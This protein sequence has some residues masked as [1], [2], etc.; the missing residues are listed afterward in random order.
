M[1]WYNELS[2][3][4]MS[5]GYLKDGQTIEERIKEMGD[6]AQS[7]LNKEGYSDK[8]QDYCKRGWFIEPTPCWTNF[9]VKNAG[10]AVSCF[11]LYIDDNTPSILTAVAEAGMQSKIGGGTSGY[12]GKIRPRGSAITGGGKSNGAVSFMPLFETNSNVI[13]QVNRRGHFSATLDIEHA[14]CDEFL[15][16]RSEGNPI[17]ELSFSISIS[18]KFMQKVYEE[19][20]VA[21]EKL[22]KVAQSRFHTGFPYIF[23]SDNVNNNTVD[24][25]KETLS[26]IFHSNMCQPKEATLLLKTNI[27]SRIITMNELKIG[28]IIWSG[29]QWTKVINK[30]SN[31]IKPVYKYN[32]STGYFLGTDNHKIFSNNNKVE[33]GKAK[34][35]DWTVGDSSVL[36]KEFDLQ[37][38]MDGL[39]LGDG[40]VHK[41]SNNLIY[42]NIGEKDYDYFNSEI[43]D[44]VNKKIG[45]GKTAYS[46]NTYI[47]HE[48][49][50]KTY[51][52]GIPDRYFY[53]DEKIKRSFLRGLFSANGSVVGTRIVLTQSSKRLIEQAREMLSSLGIHSYITSI[54]EQVRIFK[55]G[56]Y[57][58]RECFSINITSGRDLFK[59]YIGFIQLY[60]VD[61]IK[62]SNKNRYQ[63]SVIKDVEYIEDS[64]VFE[65]T[66]DADEHRY[67]TGGVLASNCHEIALPNNSK[68]SFVCDLLGMNLEYYDEWKNTDAVEVAIYFLDAMLTD[69]INI[70][71]DTPYMNKAVRFAERHRAV[72][73]GASGFHTYLQYL[74][75]PFE[76]LQA[77]GIN[78]QIFKNLHDQAYRAS[79]K[80]ALEYG[81]PDM[82]SDDKYKRRHTC[83]LAIAP[84]T[85]SSFIK[86][87]QS[88]SI[89]PYVS[90]YYIKDVAKVRVS[91]KNRFLEEVL[92][93]LGQNTDDVWESILK[94]NG[95]VQHLDFLDK[96]TKDVFKTFGEISQYEVLLQASIRQPFIDQSQSLNL[97]IPEGTNPEDVLYLIIKAH[98]LGIKTLY[99]QLNVSAAMEFTNSI[100]ECVS[101]AG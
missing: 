76:S 75:I 78:Y 80:M 85:S 43:K 14:D 68:E 56:N 18:N 17:Q 48:E 73:L 67:W 60:K 28:D 23:F 96:H 50:P 74:N 15:K 97:M 98:E 87:Q 25:Y 54:K 65:I 8:F 100:T 62:V 39:V 58:T 93:K 41:A 29:S 88:Q 42:L 31:G 27:G 86:L 95:S 6:Y 89:E 36:S 91:V 83:L 12:F 22:R 24:V 70:N 40:S 79:E 81:K 92:I 37:S 35:I 3:L 19:D 34:T 63:T 72:G 13:S 2:K 69:F 99:Y 94:N 11:G 21:I 30:W 57:T 64:E 61:K 32:T 10:S 84:N 46:I 9:G 71:K 33:I 4:F 51:L 52:R 82:L 47:E 26:T 45:V 20:P 1:R 16:I 101:C 66:V 49:L 44:L 7:I 77:K 5:R 55:N 90:N 38:I 53:A 59:E